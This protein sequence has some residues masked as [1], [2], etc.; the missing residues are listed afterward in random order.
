M[1][2]VHGRKKRSLFGVFREEVAH[3]KMKARF[4]LGERCGGDD[5][6]WQVVPGGYD[7][8]GE[9]SSADFGANSWLEN[10]EGM[11]ASRAR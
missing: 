8:V 7:A 2:T 9:R 6:A 5:I 11:S 3:C 4:E 1:S 10:L